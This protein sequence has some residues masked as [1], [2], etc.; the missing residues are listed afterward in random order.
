VTLKKETKARRQPYE[1]KP[2]ATRNFQEEEDDRREPF[3]QPMETTDIPNSESV[4]EEQ[5]L[6]KSKRGP[7]QYQ[8]N[9]WERIGKLKAD[10]TVEELAELAPVARAQLSLGLRTVKPTYG[11]ANSVKLTAKT[12]A[13]AIG[14]IGGLPVNIIIDT[15]A[16]IC[17]MS[18]R[19]LKKLGWTI[20]K[21][22]QMALVVADGRKA[23][24]LGEMCNVVIEVGGAQIPTDMVI[25]DSD[26]YDV[27]LGM[28]W[29]ENAQADIRIGESQMIIK[30]H[31]QEHEVPLNF[32]TNP[33]RIIYS[34]EEELSSEEETSVEPV[35]TV[36][37]T[38][39]K[40][41]KKHFKD[42]MQTDNYGDEEAAEVRRLRQ[43]ALANALVDPDY[44]PASI[45]CAHKC[46]FYQNDHTHLQCHAAR[47]DQATKTTP[48]EWKKFA[49]KEAQ[50]WQRRPPVNQ[51]DP[52]A[53]MSNE[54]L[55]EWPDC[56]NEL[57]RE[58][59]EHY[60]EIY[61]DPFNP[62]WSNDQEDLHFLQEEELV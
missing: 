8:Y 45:D 52:L 47:K 14:K 29:L 24:A 9:A 3:L 10:I 50:Q 21:A 58:M 18:K 57:Y 5:L 20:Y 54:L 16:G 6:T 34:S 4:A 19:L 13:Y 51:K 40:P 35:Y 59:M 46:C 11:Q 42:P 49:A 2:R 41:W 43:V 28:N 60:S 22:S 33:K 48:Q 31:G 37:R 17:I 7:R 27:I 56:D 15:G 12:P 30:S 23:V 1:R 26:S 38:T 32:T 39:K 25:M 55:P 61:H 44:I 62:L 53:K 36:T